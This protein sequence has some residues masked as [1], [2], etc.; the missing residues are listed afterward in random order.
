MT[1]R[2]CKAEKILKIEFDKHQDLHTSAW[3]LTIFC[4]ISLGLCVDLICAIYITIVTS[5]F[6]IVGNC[7]SANNRP[8]DTWRRIFGVICNRMVSMKDAVIQ[9]RINT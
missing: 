5:S 3:Y 9:I 2:A 4:A 6:S 8:G 7:K 1:I